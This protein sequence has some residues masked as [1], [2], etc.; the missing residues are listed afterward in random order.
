MPAVS[1]FEAALAHMPISSICL[2]GTPALQRFNDSTIQ[3]F[4]GSTNQQ[5]IQENSGPKTVEL[6]RPAA[7]T[8]A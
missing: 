3:R 5:R 2:S 1:L 7:E 8:S 6:L 4:N